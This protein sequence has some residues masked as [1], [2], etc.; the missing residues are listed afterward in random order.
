MAVYNLLLTRLIHSRINELSLGGV[1]L[2]GT[3]KQSQEFGI[4]PLFTNNSDVV[5]T[6]K[7]TLVY[8]NPYY[9]WW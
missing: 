7:A 1:T 2:G 6:Q 8:V 9:R 5:P 3:G 4:D